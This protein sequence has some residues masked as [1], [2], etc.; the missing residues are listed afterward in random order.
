VETKQGD[1][2]GPYVNMLVAELALAWLDAKPAKSIRSRKRPPSSPVLS[3]ERVQLLAELEQLAET[4]NDF[5]A[6]AFLAEARLLRALDAATVDDV[7]SEAML[8]RYRDAQRR[9][10]SRRELDSVLAQVRLLAR[11]AAKSAD[12]VVLALGARLEQLA[13][14]L[15]ES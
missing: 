3:P 5:W 10:R 14:R 13:S 15:T 4:K 1:A 6:L 9:G 8:D 7:T 2:F 12:K 11:V